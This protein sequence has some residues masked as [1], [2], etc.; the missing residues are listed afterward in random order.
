MHLMCHQTSALVSGQAGLLI[1]RLLCRDQGYESA[2]LRGFPADITQGSQALE[3]SWLLL[4]Q[5]P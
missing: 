4:E 3:S 5:C 1:E 2:G